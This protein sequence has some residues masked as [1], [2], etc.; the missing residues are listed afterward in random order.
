MRVIDA[1]KFQEALAKIQVRLEGLAKDNDH[2]SI[3][4][5]HSTVNTAI[6]AIAMAAEGSTVEI[7][8]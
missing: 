6:E 5:F 3:R 8:D 1:D 4:V 7:K 2:P